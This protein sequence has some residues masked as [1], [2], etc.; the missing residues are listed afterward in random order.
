MRGRGRFEALCNGRGSVGP[1]AM[2]AMMGKEDVILSFFRVRLA[3]GY[4]D[5]G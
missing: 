2:V 1:L 3:S 4:V 5:G